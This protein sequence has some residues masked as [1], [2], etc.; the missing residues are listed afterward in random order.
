LTSTFDALGRLSFPEKGQIIKL[1]QF[2]AACR[3]FEA[4]R[5]SRLLPFENL[6]FPIKTAKTNGKFASPWIFA[7]SSAN[8]FIID[9]VSLFGSLFGFRGQNTRVFWPRAQLKRKQ[10][11]QG[12]KAVT[13]RER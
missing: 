4:R 11:C 10:L 1:F 8:S 6:D 9:Q 13:E 5:I 12:P 7:T 3:K 2:E